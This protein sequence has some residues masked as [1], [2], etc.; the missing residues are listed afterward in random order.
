MADTPLR[1]SR[2]CLSHSPCLAVAAS[3]PGCGRCLRMPK[4]P[5]Q[6]ARAHRTWR[7][8]LTGLRRWPIASGALALRPVPVPLPAEGRGAWGSCR[9]TTGPAACSCGTLAAP[10]H[11]LPQRH[12]RLARLT[13]WPR[14]PLQTA[15]ACSPA[16]PPRWRTSA[17]PAAAPAGAAAPRSA[18][19]RP[20]PR[21]V[22]GRRIVRGACR[23]PRSTLHPAH[24]LTETRPG[25]TRRH[26]REA[27]RGTLRAVVPRLHVSQPPQRR[28]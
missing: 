26:R 11:R 25:L 23:R 1:S 24:S 15:P 28:R 20:C 17:P 3:A 10:P 19:R 21:S 6:S 8:C 2:R 27:A 4:R 16:A 22:A 7:S 14:P 9:C 12:R 13:A 18:G 5:R